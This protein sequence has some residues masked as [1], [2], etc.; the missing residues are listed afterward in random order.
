MRT[1]PVPEP[2]VPETGRSG[3]LQDQA[4]E[5]SMPDEM[6][7]SV[8]YEA[9]ER[10]AGTDFVAMGDLA[11]SMLAGLDASASND[12]PSGV[13]T[14]FLELDELTAGLH[15]GQMITV[16]GRPGMGK[17]T[18]GLDF[19]RACSIRRGPGGGIEPGCP[20]AV[21]SLEMSREEIMQRLYSAEARVRL[22]NM[23]TGQM[24]DTDW[25]RI[26]QIA[27]DTTSVPLFIDDS[28]SLTMMEIRSKAWRIKQ[29]HG[30]ALLVVDCLQLLTAGGRYESR[31]QEV[32]ELSRQ[33]KFL[34]KEL[35]VPVVAISQLNRGPEQRADKRPMLSDL[36]ESGAIEQDS[37]LVILL[38]RPDFYDRDSPR[39][40][41]ADLIVAKHRAGPQSTI[42]VAHQLHF[43]RFANL[44]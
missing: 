32:S 23:R 33:L 40:G 29:R 6:P 3:P 37:D 26:R 43:S 17:S 30:L 16:A 41:E 14:G 34:A 13:P 38:H 18:L 12:E 25:T 28:P 44:A 11:Q 15:P 20:S 36:R 24:S 42:V 5:Q 27:R 35:E 19:A 4:A 10:R 22:S 9:G 31:Q 7:R 1:S 2:E 39:G 21:F 8:G